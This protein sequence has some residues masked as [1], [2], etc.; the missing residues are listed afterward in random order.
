MGA[1][2]SSSMKLIACLPSHSLCSRGYLS[3]NTSFTLYINFLL[4]QA[5]RPAGTCHGHL[6]TRFFAE[7]LVG[8]LRTWP[9][10]VGSGTHRPSPSARL[11]RGGGTAAAPPGSQPD[12]RGTPVSLLTLCPIGT[13]FV[14]RPVSESVSEG[15]SQRASRSSIRS[16]AVPSCRG[17]RLKLTSQ[18]PA[19][20]AQRAWHGCSWA[21]AATEQAP[22]PPAYLP[23]LSSCLVPIFE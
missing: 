3:F 23:T 1:A 4:S 21:G 17:S 18:W 16:A 19:Q 14:H 5:S 15:C 7:R 22:S 2:S 8:R 20:R 11:L 12:R 6:V 9:E 10:Y 13:G